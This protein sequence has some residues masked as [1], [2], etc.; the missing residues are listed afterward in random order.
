[1]YTFLQRLRRDSPL[2]AAW[3]TLYAAHPLAV[4]TA[5]WLADRFDLL[6]TLFSLLALHAAFAH[7]ERPRATTLLGMLGALLL[8]LLS[9]E[10]GVVGAAA[11][12][13]AIALAPRVPLGVRQRAIALA[14]IAAL[15]LGWL[16]Y[17]RAMLISVADAS[18]HLPALASFATG[19]WNWLRAGAV[20]LLEDPRA[21][22]WSVFFVAFAIAMWAVAT[23]LSLRSKHRAVPRL[24]VA[25]ALLVLILL[26]GLVQAPV[27][28]KHLAGTIGSDMFFFHL[29]VPSRFFHLSLAGLICGLA[30]ITTP[31][32]A[33]G[34]VLPLRLST[35][36]LLLALI[37]LAPLSQR[38]AHQYARDTRKD[39]AALDAA[40]AALDRATI[41]A[42]ACQIYFL[43]TSSL[44]G[45]AGY[46]DPIAKGLAAQP[47]RLAHCLIGTERPPF[48][49][50]VRTGSVQPAD[51]RPL[52]PLEIAGKPFPI[53]E[54]GDVQARYFTMGTDMATT[55]PDSAIFLEYRDGTFIDVSAAVRS[56][57]HK[58]DFGVTP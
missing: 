4:G 45:F 5:L 39:I 20:F 11:A 42:H 19:F 38:I 10:L 33:A 56:G 49:Y 52:H 35:A 25:A 31:D 55:I 46:S 9:K 16:A 7:A 37:A 50:F 26:P 32:R 6:T 8:A 53:L 54:L 12:F 1:L 36:G 47:E 34:S 21:P 40:E 51:Y 24:H 2:N 15:T 43:Q 22:R 27:A 3:A 57:E 44:W 17:R 48:A 13:A 23:M 18:A 41:P 58:I 30:L 28:D 29:I 14:A